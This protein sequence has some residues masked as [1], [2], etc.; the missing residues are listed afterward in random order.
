MFETTKQESDVRVARI[1]L[2]RSRPTAGRKRSLRRLLL[3]LALRMLLLTLLVALP[4]VAFVR[5]SVYGYASRGFPASLALIIA[6]AV[7]ASIVALYA[8]VLSKKLTGRA[9]ARLMW[10]RVALPL[11]LVYSGYGLWYLSSLNAKSEEVR[12]HYGA[13]HPVLRIALGTVLLVDRDIVLTEV[14]RVPADYRTMGLSPRDESLHYEQR[15][16]Y[17]HAVDLRT[18]GRSGLTNWLVEQYFRSMGFS[19]IRHVG[20]ADHLHVALPVSGS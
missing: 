4:F 17:V 20:T 19:T 14:R 5:V 3:R 7:T 9:R 1:R 13:L 8:M 11:V 18:I 2:P 16:G 12:A 6:I 10:R 15:D